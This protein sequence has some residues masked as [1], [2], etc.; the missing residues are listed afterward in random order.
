MKSVKWVLDNY[1]DLQTFLDDRFGRRFA[2]FLSVEQMKQIG[3]ELKDEYKA[4]HIPKVWSEE[5]VL[6]QLKEDVEFG[7]EKA[8]NHRAISANL[9]FDVCKSW[10]VILENGLEKTE[11][12]W[13]GDK[14]FKAIDEKYGFGLVQEDTFDDTFYEEW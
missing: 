12:G 4:T 1:K 3:I 14:L 6:A 8:T 7:I 9:M 2:E 10:C 13:Y 11:Y 5:N